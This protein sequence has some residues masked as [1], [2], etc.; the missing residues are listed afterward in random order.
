MCSDDI[1]R[2]QG[3]TKLETPWS[4]CSDKVH[5]KKMLMISVRFRTSQ[6]ELYID[7]DCRSLRDLFESQKHE[8]YNNRQGGFSTDM[9]TKRNASIP[10]TLA[11]TYLSK[12]EPLRITPDQIRLVG[13]IMS[14]FIIL[15]QTVFLHR[16][17][18][19]VDNV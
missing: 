10:H 2:V 12:I 7:V 9:F 19:C 13:D 6:C 15:L 8:Y 18:G 17:G 11:G 16:R 4:F 1:H 5:R 3:A 14:D